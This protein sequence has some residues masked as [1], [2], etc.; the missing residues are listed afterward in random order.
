MHAEVADGWGRR[1]RGFEV[2][3][4]EHAARKSYSHSHV[5][6]RAT[7]SQREL[8]ELLMRLSDMVGRRLRARGPARPRGVDR[9]RLPARTWAISRGR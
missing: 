4:F 8:E 5:M 1:L 3:A 9:R 7:T 6:A 2:G